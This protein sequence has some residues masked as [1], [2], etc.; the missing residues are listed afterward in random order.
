M[1]VLFLSLCIVVA[2]VVVQRFANQIDE[3]LNACGTGTFKNSACECIHPYTG[4]HCEIVDCG[5]GKLVDSIF[6]YDTITTPKGPSGCAC[7]SQFWGYN[8][9]QC[10]SENKD[11]CTG[12]CDNNYYGPRCDILC[13]QGTE[14]TEVGVHHVE[15]GGTYNYYVEDYGF[16]KRD[17][18]VQCRAN[19]AGD[20]CEIPCKDCKYG[21]CNL[22]NG[23]CDCFDGYTG[24]LCDLTCPNRCSGLNG[25]CKEVD[26]S[27][28]CDC[29]DGFTGGD[30]SLECC[31]Q[32][33][34]TNL[35]TV[36][37]TCLE[38]IGGCNCSNE[39]FPV[40]L[41]MALE[42]NYYGQGWQG[43]E[44]DCHENITC[45]GRGL[46]IE[47]GCVCAP[48]FQGIR[49]DLCADDK[50]GPFCQ[51]D[52]FQCPSE[53]L[54]H[55]EFVP[56]NSHGDYKCKCNP[57]F[58]GDKCES[59]DSNAYPKTGPDMCKYIIPAELCHSGTVKSDYSGTG[60]MCTCP[61]HF[62]NSLDCAVCEE[63][64]YG[65]NCDIECG[66]SCTQSGGVCSNTGPGCVCP[67]GMQSTN[68]ECVTCTGGECKNGECWNGICQCDPGFYGDLC[69]ITA[70]EVSGK[71]CNGFSHVV[72]EENAQC[73]SETDCTD[74]NQPD[75]P[76]NREVAV[77]AAEYGRAMFCHRDDTPITLK[78]VSGCCV[79]RNADG[80]CDVDMLGK[81][82][83]ECKYT[84]DVGMNIDGDFLSN[85][86]NQ[87]TLENEVNVFEWCLSQ[88][89]ACT[90]NGAC[91]DPDL[92]QN[93]CDASFG[94][95]E[96]IKIWEWEHSRTMADVMSEPWKFP[97]NFSDPYEYRDSYIYKNPCPSTHPDLGGDGNHYWCYVDDTNHDLG[98][99]NMHNSGVPP[100]EGGVWGMDQST[101]VS[102]CKSIKKTMAGYVC[103]ENVGGITKSEFKG[104]FTLG[105]C[106]DACLDADGFIWK[107]TA[108]GCYCTTGTIEGCV[109]RGSTWSQY[110][111]EKDVNCHKKPVPELDAKIDDVCVVG[112]MYDVCRDYLIPDDANVF[113]LTHK[114]TGKWESMPNYQDCTL[115]KSISTTVNGKEVISISPIYAGV[116]ET[117][118]ENTAVFARYNNGNDSYTG[119]VNHMI[120]SITLFA[121]G[122]VDVL[123]YN[124]TSETCSDFVRKVGSHHDTCSQIKFHELDYDWG[125]FCKWRTPNKKT[126]ELLENG[127]HCSIFARPTGPE[128]S[129]WAVPL[130]PSDPLADPDRA[131]ECANR[132]LAEGYISF[133]LHL[134][135]WSE[136][137]GRCMCGK[138][139]CSQ[140]VTYDQRDSYR[141]TPD[142]P[143]V[144]TTRMSKTDPKP[145]VCDP[146]KLG[147]NSGH[148]GCDGARWSDDSY[149][150]GYCTGTYSAMTPSRSNY[151]P[152]L[153]HFRDYYEACCDWT[154]SA[155]VEKSTEVPAFNDT[156]YQQSTVCTAGCDN[157]Q[158]GCEGLPLL[159]EYPT[160]MPAPCNV[161]WDEFC[162]DYLSGAVREG[163]CA[164]A[165]CECEGYGVGGEACDLQCPVP[166]GVTSELSCGNGEDPPMG[167]C[168]R[169]NGATAL[170]Y[171]QGLCTCFNGGDP[172][173][174]CILSCT[175][176]Q[177]CS[178]DVDTSF[179]FASSHCNYQDKVSFTNGLCTVNLRDSLCN[180]YRGRC[181]CATPF[182]LYTD[183]NQTKY[184]NPF[185]SYRVALMQGYEIDEY[186][187]FTTYQGTPPSDLVEAFDNID[188]NFECFK[189]LDKTQEVSCDWIRA[190]KHFA[191][192]GSHRI[193]D[194]HN[195]APGTD[196][197]KQVPCS[198]HGF[199]V[200]GTCACDYAEEFDVRSTGVGLAFE[201]PG[202]T[203]TPWR[204]KNCGFLCPGYDMKSMDSVCSGHGLCTSDGRCDC[205]QGWTGYK[206]D[207]A[208]EKTQKVLSCSGHGT[209]NERLYRRGDSD[210][211]ITETFDS[212]CVSE[213][214]YLA[215]D[216]VVEFNGAIYHMY[217]NLGLKVDI[218]P[219][220]IMGGLTGGMG[221]GMVSGGR[222]DVDSDATLLQE[223]RDAV[224]DDFY[225]YGMSF[226]HPHG[227]ES[228]VPYMPCND[229]LSVKR[230][231]AVLPF[232]VQ[233]TSSVFIECNVLPGYEVRCGECTCEETSQSGHWS[234]HDCRTPALGY[235]NKD[236]RSKCPGMVDGVPCNGGGTCMWGTYEGEGTIFTADA[237][238]Y[239]GDP[240]PDTTLETAPRTDNNRFIV[241]AM[242]GD[243]PLYRK[244]IDSVD[245]VNNACPDGTVESGDVC[246]PEPLPL[247]NYNNDCSCKF[248]W[249]GST[250]E[251]PRMMC[252]FS[253]TET[254]GTKCECLDNN[255]NPNLLV[256][257]QGCCTKGTFWDQ[258]RFKSFNAINQ[259]IEID[260]NSLYLREYR[261]VCRLSPT[262]GDFDELDMHNYIIN[263]QEYTL[264]PS[265]C[266]GVDDK[267]LYNYVYRHDEDLTSGA[268]EYMQEIDYIQ[269]CLQHCGD[270]NKGSFVLT[271]IQ[272]QCQD[273]K[274]F[275]DGSSTVFD[276]ELTG[277]GKRYDILYPPG[278]FKVN[279]NPVINSKPGPSNPNHY[280]LPTRF[281]FL[282]DVVTTTTYTLTECFSKAVDAG[283]EGFAYGY[284]FSN[285]DACKYGDVPDYSSIPDDTVP[286]NGY[287]I[288][289]GENITK[290][291]DKYLPN[292]KPCGLE[293]YL[294]YPKDMDHL[295][296]CPIWDYEDC[297]TPSDTLLYS[298]AMSAMNA[299]KHSCISA[300]TLEDKGTARPVFG[301]TF[302]C[303]CGDTCSDGSGAYRLSH[304]MFK[305]ISEPNKICNL[306]TN[307]WGYIE[308]DV[309]CARASEYLGNMPTKVYPPAVLEAP[310]TQY[311]TYGC[312]LF[313]DGANQWLI[314]GGEADPLSNTY[315]QI[316]CQRKQMCICEG[317]YIRDGVAHSCPAGKYSNT[318]SHSCKECPVGQFSQEGASECGE[319]G[320]GTVQDGPM[321][322]FTCSPGTFAV[323]GDSSCTNCA[324]GKYSSSGASACTNCN[325]GQH[326]NEEG[327]TSC[328]SCTI[329]KYSSAGWTNCGNC[330]AGRYQNQ[331]GQTSCKTCSPGYYQNQNV[332]SG[333]KDCPDGYY[334]DQTGEN[335]CKLCPAG[336]FSDVT[337]LSVC[338]ECVKGQTSLEGKTSCTI[339]ED[340][341]YQDE[342]G[343]PS[344]KVCSG[345]TAT[346]TEIE[347][348]TISSGTCGSNGYQ[349]LDSFGC[350]W[351][352]KVTTK[353]YGSDPH[354]WRPSINSYTDGID[355]DSFSTTTG[356]A[357]PE[358]PSGC[359][360]GSMTNPYRRWD[361]FVAD[362]NNNQCDARWEI[363]GHQTTG[364]GCICRIEYPAAK[365]ER[366]QMGTFREDGVCKDC[367]TGKYGKRPIYYSN[368]D[369]IQSCENCPLP[370]WEHDDLDDYTGWSGGFLHGT[371]T[372]YHGYMDRSRQFCVAYQPCPES[373]S[374]RD[375]V[376]KCDELFS[377]WG[378][379]PFA[380]SSYN[381]F[382]KF[383]DHDDYNSAMDTT[384]WSMC[385]VK[386]GDTCSSLYTGHSDA[387]WDTRGIRKGSWGSTYYPGNFNEIEHDGKILC[388]PTGV[389]DLG[390]YYIG[391][392]EIS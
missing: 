306:G 344:C 149:A 71:V 117:L 221:G 195:F 354:G 392:Q 283:A 148:S 251:T 374:D 311:I 242:N 349:I 388:D 90:S 160:P 63:G 106:A 276:Q 207:L 225:I 132:C 81:T 113:N 266:I 303:W 40:E 15:K 209:C 100:P 247:E 339:C 244:V 385:C 380:S 5:Y 335:S 10:T 55:G 87:R 239:C 263:T 1:Y 327:K 260:D 188:P 328:K 115:T 24:E 296:D 387:Y 281:L 59:C 227:Y 108:S 254:D 12:S 192:G 109:S 127:A 284:E 270:L 231:E 326:Q 286:E 177:D 343:Q 61:G 145:V 41:P 305:I 338:M 165:K 210:E 250:C 129:G 318:C 135:G 336:K 285:S 32:G 173:K 187:P 258:G 103:T 189:D 274:A 86:C 273:K 110:M 378:T 39:V 202:L 302:E 150:H 52:R 38:N 51:Y 226:R 9:A 275:E 217:E 383:Q 57:G 174:G 368:D 325:A 324:T 341:K 291:V 292:P 162:P 268:I 123:I 355:F 58:A 18:S 304:D 290:H 277:S 66:T 377:M 68:G 197:A 180:F 214:M 243:T 320:G 208:C 185:E 111:F 153:D 179:T 43:S 97:V 53:A 389:F 359:I 218:Y 315:S 364:G 171:E 166:Q 23:E 219:S 308:D 246:V 249:Q 45:G 120:D 124:Y 384:I 102:N 25:V 312:A 293:S 8:C 230:E 82:S 262:D 122:Q 373:V 317:F 48:N 35:S 269:E 310:L 75:K 193:G 200:A 358:M 128:T 184:M 391:S 300:C 342:N 265:D 370:K 390:I 30:C 371:A 382:L 379:Q 22:D 31:V 137:P 89:R 264:E 366:C 54:S 329:G 65:P 107:S 114:F 183:N 241:H 36:H 376:L 280:L 271:G 357:H 76:A 46:C 88:E 138:T 49:C 316:I 181:E 199:P 93:R 299:T 297:A 28:I 240:G 198:G 69:E 375:K 201:L 236:G 272:C 351:R 332:Q 215:R 79:D 152:A 228:L 196:E 157:Y 26:G 347:Y 232:G 67:K 78:T 84:N 253:G 353:W 6:A 96:W 346:V 169:Y 44:C 85:I 60:N 176:D 133:F 99:C 3:Q 116:I 146:S 72:Q 255:N 21:Q 13:M 83:A 98:V 139:D 261:H 125:A 205:D 194:C 20:H 352:N 372:K 182:T 319:C 252:L 91:E 29:Y 172:T 161:G 330:N 158:E 298:V 331:N 141:I 350:E 337:G 37:G 334:Q 206:C 238:C 168:D 309:T 154:G 94:P 131:Q 80:F 167:Q 289:K 175:G 164:Y 118:Q 321:T 34:G 112:D 163:T 170:G 235:Y 121:K 95:A 101:C 191:R 190:L 7:E 381:S 56:V 130:D 224:L 143:T 186:M 234:G 134:G 16:C 203:E 156:C 220:P 345:Y 14:N 211:I 295:C 104:Q 147:I 313:T 301:E 386:S 2:A 340:G 287:I 50:I 70:P 33:R 237:K 159:S 245:K 365:C 213:P 144:Y 367:P 178:K 126:Y 278:C 212:N 267:P 42:L 361:Y 360:W 229:T 362:T 142:T 307:K 77:R 294:T 4:T 356:T 256:N 151:N 259:F 363:W 11:E 216:R 279:G 222:G 92:C 204:G 105:K 27:P 257:E 233:G 348:P 64:W 17:G 223:T 119:T 322:C 282:E 288:R 73:M 136:G 140:R 62:D 333:C 74:T 47:G 155:C 369:D 323:K 314:N 19:R 248:G